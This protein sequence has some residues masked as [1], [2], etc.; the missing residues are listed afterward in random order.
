VLETPEGKNKNEA[1]NIYKE[2]VIDFFSAN[3]SKKIN[4]YNQIFNYKDIWIT[5][6]NLQ[7]SNITGNTLF[8]GLF[9]ANY[10]LEISANP[11]LNQI[12]L[13]TFHNLGGRDYGGSIFMMRKYK[14]EIQS[15]FYPM[16]MLSSI[17]SDSAFVISKHIISEE[18]TEYVVENNNHTIRYSCYLNWSSFNQEVIIEDSYNEVVKI[19]EYYGNNLFSVNDDKH[20]IFYKQ[21][22]AHSIKKYTILPYSLTLIKSMIK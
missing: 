16:K 18:F 4:Q 2:R 11:Q 19:E 5:E 10:L 7:Y 15:T 14:S 12:K 21:T 1:F 8:Q 22:K 13:A 3:F 20:E 6:W 17:L 9:S